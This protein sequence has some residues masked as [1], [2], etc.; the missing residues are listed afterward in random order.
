MIASVDG[1]RAICATKTC[2]CGHPA[3]DGACGVRCEPNDKQWEP[4]RIRQTE[5]G[6]RPVNDCEGQG[7]LAGCYRR[8][9][10]IRSWDRRK[11]MIYEWQPL[12][13]R[14]RW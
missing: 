13:G 1:W 6:H 12:V 3:T 5:P 14:G 11:T 2:V 9:V 8:A 10:C 7:L 4:N